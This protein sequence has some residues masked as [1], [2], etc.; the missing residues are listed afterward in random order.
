[1]ADPMRDKENDL[2][3]RSSKG[4]FGASSEDIE[5]GY[6]A[7]ADGEKP[8]YELDNYKRRFTEEPDSPFGM[9]WPIEPG[10]E[11]SDWAFQTRDRVTKGLLTRPLLT[12]R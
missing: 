3:V 12:E 10:E 6:C 4:G 11:E 7:P 1:M 5:R 9:A 2:P 8:G